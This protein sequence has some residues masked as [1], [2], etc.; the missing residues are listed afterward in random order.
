MAA[1]IIDWARTRYLDATAD[2]KED[3]AMK[4]NSKK[5]EKIM[6]QIQKSFKDLKD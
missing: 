1:E 5:L 2:C 6:D 3:V 4:V